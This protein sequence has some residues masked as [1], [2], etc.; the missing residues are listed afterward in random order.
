MADLH[1]R[2][3]LK[4]IEQAASSNRVSEDAQNFGLGCFIV[5]FI[6]LIVFLLFLTIA[7]WV[8]EIFIG[9]LLT[10]VVSLICLLILY[11]LWTAPKIP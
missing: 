11:K 7:L 6:L 2:E 8:N 4:Q 3:K 9:S 5:A 10:A 1:Y